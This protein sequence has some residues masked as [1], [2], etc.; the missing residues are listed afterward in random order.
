VAAR[1]AI[2]Q[3]H[4][5]KYSGNGSIVCSRVIGDVV[6]LCWLI[7]HR[8]GVMCRLSMI[9]RGVMQLRSINGCVVVCWH[10]PRRRV[11]TWRLGMNKRIVM[12]LLSL[13]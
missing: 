2:C 10:I 12:L 5:L 7:Q 11:I 6:I 8:H 9:W 4:L 13:N 1:R 3:Q